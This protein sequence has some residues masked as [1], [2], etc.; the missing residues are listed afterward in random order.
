MQQISKSYFFVHLTSSITRLINSSR[1]ILDTRMRCTVQLHLKLYHRSTDWADRRSATG[2]SNAI[3]PRVIGK[4]NYE[5]SSQSLPRV[6]RA[7]TL[8]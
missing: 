3:Q 7:N 2:Y 1:N 5:I 6:Q 4:P 8:N